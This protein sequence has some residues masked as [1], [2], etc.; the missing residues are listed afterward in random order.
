M[1]LL[2]LYV[3]VVL[4]GLIPVNN[5]FQPADDG[6]EILL[7]SNAV[8][9]DIILPIRTDVIDWREEFP[10]H[11]FSG[12]VENATH[13]AIG[14]GD[15]GFYIDTPRWSDLR[16]STVAKALFWPTGSCLHVSFTMRDLPNARTVRITPEQYANLVHFIKKSMRSSERPETT[17]IRGAAYLWYDAFFE[18]KGRYHCFNTCNCW[19]GRA[20][21]AAGIRTGWFTPLPKTVFLYLPERTP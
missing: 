17:L 18:A 21:Q 2:L 19:T 12:N 15:K 4:I 16:A 7:T 3:I 8:H 10:A 1:A 13:V 20:M 5:D 6:I 9:A 11:C 14:W